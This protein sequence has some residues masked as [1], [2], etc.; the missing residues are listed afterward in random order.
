[1]SQAKS[2]QF[3]R[4]QLVCNLVSKSTDGSEAEDAVVEVLNAVS[5]FEEAWLVE[6]V[7]DAIASAYCV[8]FGE[9]V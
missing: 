1:M 9:G 8:Q 4:W 7:L 6:R 2:E 3:S 5:G